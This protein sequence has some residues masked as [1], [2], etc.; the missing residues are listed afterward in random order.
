MRPLVI[1]VVLGLLV[2]G[3]GVAEPT[4]RSTFHELQ[5]LI[6]EVSNRIRP[7][8]VHV[9][10]LS[11][12]GERYQKVVGS[13]LIISED[14][15][16]VTNYHVIDR[17]QRIT[18]IL[19]DNT[20]HPAR[21][22]RQDPQT[23]LA[24]L[25]IDAGRKLPAARLADSDQ[26]SVGQWVLAVGNP[27]GFDRTVS[28][29]IVSGK[30]RYIPGVDTE[31]PLLND[32]IQ[33]DALIDPGSSGGP[34]V[35]LDG[36]VIGINSVG[37]G[38]GQG[39]TIPSRVV[40][41]VITGSEVEGRL[42]RGWIGIFLRHLPRELAAHLGAP[43]VAGVLV[44]DVVPGSPAEQAGLRGKDI[45]TAL[46]G[47][48]VDAITEEETNRFVQMVTACE[49][50][51]RVSLDVVRQGQPLKVEVVIGT[52]PKMDARELESGVGL[53]VKEITQSVYYDYRLDTREGVMVSYVSRG[54]PAEEAGLEVGDVLVE[55]EGHPVTDIEG[56]QKAMDRLKGRRRILVTAQRGKITHY[57]L[58]DLTHYTPGPAAGP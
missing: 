39:F 56:F 8:V 47:R 15:R 44:N 19:D 11:R 14:G 13:G 25:R 38:R 58:I 57:A 6:V 29:G 33:T 51:T 30:G 20:R 40:R 48:P 3:P 9:E 34:L 31:V 27:Y 41:Q 32:F 23:D 21:V 2:A 22:I 37:I 50:G 35:N 1:A 45:I 28:F 49:P 26:V 52:Q 16:I 43:G 36:E 10:V 7:S 5:K 55:L 46:D 17:A 53:T 24:L 54:S 12:R 18:V 42:K 4:S